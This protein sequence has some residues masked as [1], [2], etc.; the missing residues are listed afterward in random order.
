MFLHKLA[1]SGTL[2]D[3]GY[4]DYIRDQGTRVQGLYK[5][6]GDR[7]TRV[8][9]SLLRASLLKTKIRSF[10]SIT[11]C[12]HILDHTCLGAFVLEHTFDVM[13]DAM[14]QAP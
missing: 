8:P 12:E 7:G 9:S 13:C 4:Q 14:D 3:A 5:G 6:P 1:K 2:H 10:C 11:I